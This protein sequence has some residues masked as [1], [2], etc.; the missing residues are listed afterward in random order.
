MGCLMMASI[1]SRIPMNLRN[2]KLKYSLLGLSL[3]GLPIQEA[4]P[5]NQLVLGFRRSRDSFSVCY[6]QK[7]FFKGLPRGLSMLDYLVEDWVLL[8][9]KLPVGNVGGGQP[10]RS[11]TNSYLLAGLLV[12]WIRPN[13]LFGPIC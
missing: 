6:L 12:I 5:H 9:F 3:F 2:N 4:V 13:S 8:L 11:R 7:G 10:S 1:K